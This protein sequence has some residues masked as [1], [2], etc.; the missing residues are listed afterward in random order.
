[1]ASDPHVGPP[2]YHPV[3]VACDPRNTH[4]MVTKPMDCLQLSA[5]ATPPTSSLLTSV[6]SALTDSQWCRAMEDYMALLSNS[7]W[8]L[9]PQAPGANVVTGK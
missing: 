3:I 4:P 8:D 6:H 1:V 2:V 9:V 7:T 5:A